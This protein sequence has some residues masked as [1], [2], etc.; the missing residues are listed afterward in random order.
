MIN[1]L[2]TASR[3]AGTFSIGNA[4]EFVLASITNEL[5]HVNLNLFERSKKSDAFLIG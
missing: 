5:Q 2:A 1:E 3:Q 4:N